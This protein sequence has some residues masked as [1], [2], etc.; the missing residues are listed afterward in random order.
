VWVVGEVF[1]PEL[2]ASL[3]QSGGQKKGRWMLSVQTASEF[4]LRQVIS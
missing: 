1:M 2:P 3:Q 4:I